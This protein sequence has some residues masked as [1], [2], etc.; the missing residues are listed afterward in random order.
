MIVIPQENNLAL[1]IEFAV[2]AVSKGISENEGNLVVV[3]LQ[4]FYRRRQVVL[5]SFVD[6]A[7][8]HT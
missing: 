5:Y 3:Q 6:L 4:V 8:L 7:E 2:D 1:P